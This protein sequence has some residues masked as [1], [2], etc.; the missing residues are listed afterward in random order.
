MNKLNGHVVSVLSDQNVTIYEC[1]LPTKH[2]IAGI[3]ACVDTKPTFKPDDAVVVYFDEMDV[4]LAKYFSEDSTIKKRF[5]AIVASVEEG[6][7]LTRVVLDYQGVPITAV[8]RT[9][10]WQSL[11][12][13]V[14]S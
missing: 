4:I 2:V 9:S 10:S 6:K 5:T 1:M 11:G 14:G 3:S 13:N 7:A 8:V 12:L